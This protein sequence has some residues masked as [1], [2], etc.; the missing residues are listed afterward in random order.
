[1]NF[2]DTLSRYIFKMSN[3]VPMALLALVNSLERLVASSRFK[4]L[5]RLRSVTRFCS[6]SA[7]AV[8]ILSA[9]PS[10]PSFSVMARRFCSSMVPMTVVSSF[11]TSVVERALPLA[12]VREIPNSLNVLPVPSVSLMAFCITS[13]SDLRLSAASSSLR[14]TSFAT[15]LNSCMAV[16]VDRNW[17][18]SFANS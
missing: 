13:S 16:A 4:P 11:I 15:S 3:S 6:A 5:A 10:R 2:S 18:A 14:P 7:S 8:N 12:S 9:G 17:S 1:M